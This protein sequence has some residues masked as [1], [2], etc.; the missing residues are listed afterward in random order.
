M[1]PERQASFNE[2]LI[3]E[4]SKK[5]RSGNFLPP[6]GGNLAEHVKRAREKLWTSGLLREKPLDLPEI[7]ELEVL[8]H[9]TRLAQMNFGINSGFYPLGSCTMKYNPVVNELLT[10]LPAVTDVHPD[11]PE[12]T[13]QG[14]LH[15]YYHVQE[16]IGAIMGLPAVSLQPAAGAHGEFAGLLIMR[17][18]HKDQGELGKRTE[19]LV[20]DTAHGTNPASAAMAGFKVVVLPSNKIGCE[21]EDALLGCLDEEALT[22]AVSEHTAGF[23]LTNPSTLGTFEP[24][25]VEISKIV[26][27]A[28][29]LLYYDGANL[30]SILGITRPGDMGFDIA[31]VNLHKTFSTP[32]GGGGPG[33]GAVCVT[34]NLKDYLPVP[35]AAK[36]QDSSYYLD[37]NLS[38]SIGKLKGYFGNSAIVARAY[39]YIYMMGEAGLRKAAQMAVLNANYLAKKIT[40]STPLT[41]PY[42]T[43]GLVKH[44]MVL[45]ASKLKKETGVSAL[46][47]SKGLLD[48][49]V[50][51]PTIYFPQLVEEALMIEPTD[52]ETK[53]TLDNYAR[54]LEDIC[55][56]AETVPEEIIGAPHNTPVAR[57]DE[58]MAA[59]NPVLSYRM[60]K[61]D[62]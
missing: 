44:E 56:K 61:T 34:E 21:S 51:P 36:R 2:P 3:F 37:Y 15:I 23:M 35:I 12:S 26:H 6:A 55:K 45:S 39:L 43:E 41:L 28:G 62:K 42:T 4:K 17:T 20:P 24:N 1:L 48:N 7:S 22:E 57:I 14:Y 9:F 5:G 18:Y 10:S 11:Q 53:E 60:K 31:H 50:H 25:I 52:T 32:H 8:R 54:I 13:V 16:W 58:V 30:N 47:I 27:E 59:R 33:A 49:Y 19:I 46:D 38:K 40:S 29:G